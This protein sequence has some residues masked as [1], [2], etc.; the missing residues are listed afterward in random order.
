MESILLQYGI[1]SIRN[2]KITI[3]SLYS[4]AKLL[5]KDKQ[6]STL[7]AIKLNYQLQNYDFNSKFSNFDFM[8]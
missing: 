5:D 7:H 6:Y 4:F 2:L 8:F 3:F 1:L